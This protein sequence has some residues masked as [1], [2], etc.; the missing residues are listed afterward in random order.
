MDTN[1]IL[2]PKALLS[3]PSFIV[4]G[5]V[6]NTDKKFLIFGTSS[7]LEHYGKTLKSFHKNDPIKRDIY[8]NKVQC[9][10]LETM[11]DYNNVHYDTN[12]LL[13]VGKAY[14][15]LLKQGYTP[16]KSHRFMRV[17]IILKTQADS[18]VNMYARTTRGTDIFLGQFNNIDDAESYKKRWYGGDAVYKLYQF[19]AEQ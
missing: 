16:Y 5:L 19:K 2:S 10:I 6:N 15:S 12:T 13:L 8:N 3:L 11:N 14:D 18:R 9:L 1:N 17:S 4:Y 7:L